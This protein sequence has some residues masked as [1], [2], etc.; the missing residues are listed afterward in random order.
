MEVHHAHA[1]AKGKHFRH[2][3]FE[4]LMLFLAVSAG[5]FVENIREH[6]VEKKRATGLAA[7]LI[8]DMQ[9]DTAQLSWLQQFGRLKQERL[10][11]LY[12]LLNQ[13]FNRIS[14][15]TYY[16]LAKNIQITFVFAPSNGTINQLKNAGYLRYFS[17]DSLPGFLSEYDF[18]YKD[19][20]GSD[21][22]VTNLIYNKYYD[23]LIKTSD[24]RL[25]HIEMANKELPDSVGIP[26][27]AAEDLKALKGIIILIRRS[28]QAYNGVYTDL[29]EKA[30]QIMG[31]LHRSLHL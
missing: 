29:K 13:P 4:F 7:S 23:L 21:G 17:N 12:E 11:S 8:K 28:Y 5:F 25:L 14:T 20:E 16:R 6:M 30:V 18:L 9:K 2:Y 3:L 1:P 15:G 27:I 10:D 19:N 26:P 31:Y 22:I 24:S